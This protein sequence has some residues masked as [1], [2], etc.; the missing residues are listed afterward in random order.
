[1]FS[2]L[3]SCP[4]PSNDRVLVHVDG[5]AVLPGELIESGNGDPFIVERV[6]ESGAVIARPER[7]HER[8]RA[9]LREHVGRDRHALSFPHL[10]VGDRLKV[11]PPPGHGGDVGDLLTLRCGRW[12]WRPFRIVQVLPDGCVL[13]R[14]RRWYDHPA[15]FALGVSRAALPEHRRLRRRN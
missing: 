3:R 8:A 14:P 15:A 4:S 2:L 5:D 6:L 11:H 12:R 13:I 10:V 7:W 9:W 1:M